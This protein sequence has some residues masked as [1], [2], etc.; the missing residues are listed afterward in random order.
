VPQDA[1]LA[2]IYSEIEMR[3]RIELAKHDITA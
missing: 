2:A 1:A 3:V